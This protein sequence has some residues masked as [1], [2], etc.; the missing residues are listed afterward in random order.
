MEMDET[1][2]RLFSL[3]CSH[4]FS[5]YQHE[6]KCYEGRI[7]PLSRFQ[8]VK[9]NYIFLLEKWEKEKSQWYS[10]GEVS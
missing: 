8:Y 3:F 2:K 5:E 4:Y 6:Y 7:A 10:K 9:E 1:E